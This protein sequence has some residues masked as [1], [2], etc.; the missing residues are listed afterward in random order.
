MNEVMLMTGTVDPISSTFS[1]ARILRALSNLAESSWKSRHN[2]LR[3]KWIPVKRLTS[4]APRAW[5]SLRQG[6]LREIQLMDC[7]KLYDSLHM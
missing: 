3:I 7:E 1:G 2:S 4:K 5:Q 6:Q